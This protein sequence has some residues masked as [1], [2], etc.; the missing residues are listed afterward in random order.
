MKRAEKAGGGENVRF[1]W[2]PLPTPPARKGAPKGLRDATGTKTAMA[3]PARRPEAAMASA[4]RRPDCGREPRRPSAAEAGAKPSRR[5]PFCGGMPVI[6]PNARVRWGNGR[7]RRPNA[8]RNRANARMGATKRA[9]GEAKGANGASKRSNGATK[10]SNGANERANG[11][12]KPKVGAGIRRAGGRAGTRGR[13]EGKMEFRQEFLSGF[14]FSGRIQ[15]DGGFMDDLQLLRQYVKDG[16]Q[17]AFAGIVR[18][19]VD[20]VYGTARRLVGD[21]QLAEDVAQAAFWCWRRR[22]NRWSRGGWRA[23][24]SM[25]RG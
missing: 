5:N 11:A 19:H 13:G 12:S 2:W 17:D 4:R 18:Q 9:D 20:L 3:V 8:Q 25:L 24:W 22:R 7:T 21:E 1:S 10:R 15:V 6:R 23:G 14:G 16:S